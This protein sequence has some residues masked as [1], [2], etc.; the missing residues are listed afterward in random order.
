MYGDD[1]IRL[2]YREADC[3][4]RVEFLSVHDVAVRSHEIIEDEES[5]T[6]ELSHVCAGG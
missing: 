6:S 2:V 3:D 5:L 1:V 4:R